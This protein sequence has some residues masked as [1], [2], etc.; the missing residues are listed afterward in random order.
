MYVDVFASQVGHNMLLLY[1]YS[2][3]RSLV[4]T[5]S[6]WGC[7]AHR[8]YPLKSSSLPGCGIAVHVARS[9]MHVRPTGAATA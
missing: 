5:R 8:T 3:P 2:L 9:L 4:I 6:L 1:T 7:I